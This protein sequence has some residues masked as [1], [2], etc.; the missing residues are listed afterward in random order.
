MSNIS[1]EFSIP[2]R[3]F[4]RIVQQ[5]T[6]ESASDLKWTND[7]LTLI[8]SAGEGELISLFN[9]SQSVANHAHRDGVKLCDILLVRNELDRT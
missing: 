7:A 6:P 5:A 8:Q 4:R 1:N 9:A 3:S 2:R